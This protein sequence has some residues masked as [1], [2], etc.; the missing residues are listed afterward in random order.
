MTGPLDLDQVT[1]VNESRAETEPGDVSVFRTPQAACAYLESW[2]VEQGEGF[3]LTAGGDRL[4][5]TSHPSVSV[6]TR[7]PHPDGDRLVRLWLAH[8]AHHIRQARKDAGP[9][10]AALQDLIA[11]VGFSR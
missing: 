5:L 8:L 3:L 11:Y 10:T 1:L 4:L 2:W 6:R 7:E 9:P